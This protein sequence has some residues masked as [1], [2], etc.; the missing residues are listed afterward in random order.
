MPI[1]R[2]TENIAQLQAQIP[3]LNTKIDNEITRA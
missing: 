1:Q 2:N 3:V